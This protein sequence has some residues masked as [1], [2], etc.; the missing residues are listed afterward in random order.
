MLQ[1]IPEKLVSWKHT[2]RCTSQKDN[3]DN[4][5]LESRT[6]SKLIVWMPPYLWS[7]Y[8]TKPFPEQ[9]LIF[10][11]IISVHW[12]REIHEMWTILI[13]SV[14]I[15][16]PYDLIIEVKLWGMLGPNNHILPTFYKEI[17]QISWN[18]IMGKSLNFRC[19]SWNNQGIWH[20]T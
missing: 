5:C 7:P 19:H 14:D 16:L 18:K 20:E 9:M 4:C 3:W 1:Y 17:H 13:I 6:N 15:W 10:Q 8:G 11:L 12:H 2:S